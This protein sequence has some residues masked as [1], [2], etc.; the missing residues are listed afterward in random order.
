MRKVFFVIMSVFVVILSNCATIN[1]LT[2]GSID[3]DIDGLTNLANCQFFISKD[4]TLRFLSDNR[5]TGINERSGIVEAERVIRSRAIKIAS[6]TPGILQTRDNAGNS[7]KGYN[8][9][10][11]QGVDVLTLSI[12]FEKDNDNVINFSAFY[13]DKMQRFELFDREVNY[14]GLTYT[15]LYKGNDR[16]YL[17]YKIMERTREQNETRKAGGRKVGS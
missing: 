10:T 5:Q 16:P 7:L 11:N 17:R 9:W 12:L 6:S 15:I 2:P 13:N 4:V 8:V 1:I 3:V 14:G